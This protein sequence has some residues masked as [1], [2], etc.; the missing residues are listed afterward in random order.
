MIAISDVDTRA[1]VTYIRENGAMNAIIST[2]VDSID[3]L[4]KQ[5]EEVPNMDGLEWK[6]QKWNGFAKSYLR[7]A[8]Y[9]EAKYD[10]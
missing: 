1:L 9:P 3:K 5:L 4:K 6:R 10:E 7:A 2:E 8:Y